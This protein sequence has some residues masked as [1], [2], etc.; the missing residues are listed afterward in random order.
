MQF[1]IHE[2]CL[3]LILSF[4]SIL[5]NPQLESDVCRLPYT[6]CLNSLFLEHFQCLERAYRVDKEN[7]S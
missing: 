2:N 4:F 1:L 3:E 5:R 7:K 6:W